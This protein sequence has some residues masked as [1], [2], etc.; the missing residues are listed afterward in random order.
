MDDELEYTPTQRA[1]L[2]GLIASFASRA[3][4]RSFDWKDIGWTWLQPTNQDVAVNE[5]GETITVQ[6]LVDAALI[7]AWSASAY[8]AAAIDEPI[9]EVIAAFGV[10]LAAMDYPEV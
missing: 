3:A 7:L 6:D 1:A 10:G 8:Y 2:Q 9:E 5:D 4:A